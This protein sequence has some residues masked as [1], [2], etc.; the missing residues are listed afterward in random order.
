MGKWIILEH[1]DEQEFAE[2]MSLAVDAVNKITE[3]MLKLS[4]EIIKACGPLI[5]L[6]EKLGQGKLDDGED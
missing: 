4:E 5:D 2:G 6:N 1:T 3:A